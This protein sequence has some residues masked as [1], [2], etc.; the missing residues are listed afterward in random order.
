MGVG[1]MGGHKRCYLRNGK[2]GRSIVYLEGEGA[3]ERERKRGKD[4]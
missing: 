4:G 1:E 2:T 3:I